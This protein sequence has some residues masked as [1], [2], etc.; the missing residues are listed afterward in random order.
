METDARN[1]TRLKNR[2]ASIRWF[3]R[4]V[5]SDPK[6]TRAWIELGL[7]YVASGQEN[8]AI[9]AFQEAIES[10]PSL[11]LPR[12]VYESVLSA[13]HRPDA[14]IDA[15]REIV[16]IAPND[17]Q[18][19]VGLD[20]SLMQRKRYSEALPYLQTAAKNDPSP[21]AQARLDTAYLQSGQIEKGSAVLEK[22][23]EDKTIGGGLEQRRVR[24]RRCQR[25]LIF[26]IL[27]PPIWCSRER[28]A[29]IGTRWAGF[30][31]VLGTSIRPRAF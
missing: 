20:T 13:V 23:V 18:A 22:M 21:T 6:F 30:I 2:A 28:L 17:P 3:K 14:A 12:K 5:E 19:I 8:P 24:A 9:N 4:V 25:R 27:F 7:A 31:F 1:S 15:L 29:R 11:L 16:K 26:P 10:A